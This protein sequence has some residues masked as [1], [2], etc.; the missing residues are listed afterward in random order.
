MANILDIGQSALTAAQIGL[1]TTGHNIANANTPGYSRQIVI[2]GAATPQDAGFGFV[3]KGTDVV[4]V[5]RVY[6]QYLANRVLTAQTS[7][8]SLGSYYSQI[9]QVD[10]MFADST[11]GLSP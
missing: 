9:Q 2:Q 10:N 5:Q 6:D 7:S 8:N 11:V 3:G 4:G 1:T